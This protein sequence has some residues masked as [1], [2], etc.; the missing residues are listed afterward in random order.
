MSAAPNN[1]NAVKPDEAKLEFPVT[2]R[3]TK[4]ERRAWRKAAAG[5]KFNAWGRIVLNLAARIEAETT[6]GN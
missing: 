1:T 2:I 4:A 6:D 5:G 3:G